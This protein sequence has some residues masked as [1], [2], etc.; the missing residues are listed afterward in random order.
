MAPE[1]TVPNSFLLEEI[2]ENRHEIMEN[3]KLLAGKVGRGELV[4]WL[5]ATGALLG[6][7]VRFGGI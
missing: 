7:L 4:G 3:R 2:R 1:D 5:S 6:L